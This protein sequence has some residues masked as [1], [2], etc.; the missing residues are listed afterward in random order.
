MRQEPTDW[1]YQ[2]R[3]LGKLGQ[4][5]DAID[6]LSGEVSKL[7]QEDMCVKITKMPAMEDTGF[8]SK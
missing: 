8:Y 5:V 3:I 7:T 2:E 1:D 6:E 4:L